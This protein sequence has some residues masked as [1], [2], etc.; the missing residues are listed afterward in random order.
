MQIMGVLLE[1]SQGLGIGSIEK[2]WEGVII[3]CLSQ[4]YSFEH[5]PNGGKM[6]INVCGIHDG[7]YILLLTIDL[8]Y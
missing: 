7:M 2:F 5:V 6:S 1:N 4:D 3:S 8:G